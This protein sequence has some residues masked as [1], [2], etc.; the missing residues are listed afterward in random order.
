[1][2]KLTKIALALLVATTATQMTLA[3]NK[4]SLSPLEI[5]DPDLAGGSYDIRIE[6]Q[7]KVDQLKELVLEPHQVRDVK[8][9]LLDQQRARVSPY[10]SIPTPTTR[11]LNVK[12]APGVVP[13]VIRLSANMLST[14]VFSDAAGNPWNIT[15]VALNRQ[16]FSDGTSGAVLEQSADQASGTVPGQSADSSAG[17]QTTFKRNH[18][19]LSLEPLNP[20]AYGNVAVSLEGLDTP[21]I[22]IL[23]TGQA[24]VDMRVDA[25]IPGLNPHRTAKAFPT[26]TTTLHAVDDATLQFVDGAP[27][28]GAASLK[29]SSREVDAWLYGEEVIVRT[30]SQ[31]IYPAF[32]A[33]VTSSSGMTVYRFD[34]DTK[35][36]TISKGT[37]SKNIFIEM[38]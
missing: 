6:K 13:P 27:P 38:E 5:A 18:N 20:V 30:D 11:S 14:I 28:E 26:Q 4:D 7:K 32:T 24:E 3:N 25:R 8:N 1:M 2:T 34:K 17:T 22:F 33:S 12:F 10:S 36:L 21:V 15:N 9:I 35:A 31:I 23:S 19:V 37:S 16:M 29:T